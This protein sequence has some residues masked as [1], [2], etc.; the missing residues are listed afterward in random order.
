MVAGS[1]IAMDGGF[2]AGYEDWRALVEGSKTCFE[3]YLRWKSLL[4]L[5]IEN[6]DCFFSRSCGQNVH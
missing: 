6:Y 1:C 5:G 2:F 4:G 3:G